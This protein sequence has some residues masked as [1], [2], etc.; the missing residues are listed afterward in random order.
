MRGSEKNKNNKHLAG[1]WCGTNMFEGTALQ[2][3]DHRYACLHVVNALGSH[4]VVTCGNHAPGH[5]S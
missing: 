4:F 2:A 1:F 5:E 3:E